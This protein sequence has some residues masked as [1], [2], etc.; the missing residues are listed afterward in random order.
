[1]YERAAFGTWLRE[2]RRGLDLTQE[3]LAGL[4]GCSRDLIKKLELGQRRPSRQMAE[5]IAEALDLPLK[6]RPVF[7]QWARLEI[8]NINSAHPLAISTIP[9]FHRSGSVSALESGRDNQQEQ[10]VE[11]AEAGLTNPYKGLRA[12]EEADAPYFFGREA[13]VSKLLARLDEKTP[14][15]HFLAI[16]GPSGCGKSSLVRAGLIPALRSMG[17]PEGQ[18]PIVV[19]MLPGTAPDQ[20]LHSALVRAFINEERNDNDARNHNSSYPNG[21]PRDG[22][23]PHSTILGSQEAQEASV[24]GGWSLASMV[25]RAI[26]STGDSDVALLL[27]IDQF[28]EIFTLADN[29]SARTS[30]FAD[31]YHAV[32]EPTN[33]IWVVVTLRAD[34]YDR[35]LMCPGISELFRERTEAVGPMSLVE[36]NNAIVAPA[37]RAGLLLESG[38]VPTIEG[39]VAEQPSALPL[40]EYALTEL[41]ERKSGRTLTLDAY[42]ESGGVL[43]AIGDRAEA[44]YSELTDVEQEE[45]RQ[46]FLRLV[47]L[48]EEGEESRRRTPRTELASAAQDEEALDL[49]LELFGRYRLLTFDRDAATRRPTVEVAHEALIRTWPRL[50]SWLE[51][52][53]ETLRLQ[54]QLMAA[55]TE[56]INS[57]KEPS[58]L[59]SGARLARFESL[60]QVDP[61]PSDS[62]AIGVALT[63]YERAYLQASLK[64]RE[65]E[66]TA[67]GQS[68]RRVTTGLV[69]ALVLMLILA[70]LAILQSIQANDQRNV[71]EIE[72]KLAFSRELAAESEAQLAIDPNL[73]LLLAIEAGKLS[74]NAEAQQ[75]LQR[76]LIETQ[77]HTELRYPGQAKLTSAA[78]SPDG[79]EVATTSDISTIRIWEVNDST[80]T[81]GNV[82]TELFLRSRTSGLNDEH[83]VFSPDAGRVLVVDNDGEARL[84]DVNTQKV[85][86]EFKPRAKADVNSANFSPDGKYVVTASSD[87]LATIWDATSGKSVVQLA[88]HGG[89]VRYAAFS[90]DGAMVVTASLDGTARVWDAHTGK[91]L[92]ELTGHTGDVNSATFSP[93]GKYIVTAGDD[94]TA[95]LWDVSSGQTI[96]TFMGHTDTVGTATFSPDSK[97]IVTASADGSTRVWDTNTGQMLALILASVITPATP[98]GLSIAGATFSPDGQRILL[99]TGGVDS[100]ARIYPW[101]LFTPFQQLLALAPTLANRQLTCEERRT[102][103]H[104]TAPCGTPTP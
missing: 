34:F 8:P 37:E 35:P 96:R 87:N 25:D 45:A 15:A 102:Y 63:A 50:R 23:S 40:L 14:L 46:I 59:A 27:F 73:A 18:K 32:T 77:P 88:G 101:E 3:K 58:F 66:R 41:F 94:K 82:L 64:E 39:D 51:V 76:A 42:R 89:L 20:E 44:I 99:V 61:G 56:W 12:F 80:G 10:E 33:R 60:T 84:W 7:V 97:Y 53:R 9:A 69:V 48:G 47:T 54:R 5:L 103:L 29:E 62:A 17:L 92:R 22:H 31:L 86:M 85:V 49:V 100:S 4:V 79:K 78:F 2:R 71:A 6:E 28:E 38:L 70:G 81:S 75:A 21:Q 13:L 74:D 52:N 19:S 57:G 36:I 93:D 24:N 98:A 55:S 16:V 90:P 43:Q 91:E 67:R 68:R 30:F 65:R 72:Q 95:R 104:E 83:I 26:S 1:V 11:G